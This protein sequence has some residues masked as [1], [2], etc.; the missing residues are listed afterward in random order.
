MF[1]DNKFCCF[2]YFTLASKINS[3]K[4]GTIFVELLSLV[5]VKTSNE[6]M[7]EQMF[8]T[9]GR[10]HTNGCMYILWIDFFHINNFHIIKFQV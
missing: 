1:E 9:K 4:L 2:I 3:L 6:V 8:I 10:T 5:I 7:H